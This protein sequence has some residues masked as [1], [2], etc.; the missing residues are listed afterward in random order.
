MDGHVLTKDQT[1]FISYEGENIL[2][3]VVSDVRGLL[4]LQSEVGVHWSD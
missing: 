1:F 3:T 2:M 4:T